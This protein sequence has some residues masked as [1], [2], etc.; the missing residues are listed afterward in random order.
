M[1]VRRECGL[2][3]GG[4][5]SRVPIRRG[6]AKSEVSME[7]QPSCSSR[8]SPGPRASSCRR[9]DRPD[10]VAGDRGVPRPGAAAAPLNEVAG[11]ASSARVRDGRGRR[12]RR[13]LPAAGPVHRRSPA[14]RR[15]RQSRRPATA[16]TPHMEL[17]RPDPGV[18]RMLERCRGAAGPSGGRSQHLGLLEGRE[19]ARPRAAARQDEQRRGGAVGRIDERVSPSGNWPVAGRCRHSHHWNVIEIPSVKFEPRP[20]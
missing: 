13:D 20:T 8:N 7:F 3:A 4:E 14:S 6:G 1:R 2:G 5:G 12:P 16:R 15:S 10:R 11:F 19:R 18:L 9:R 17:H